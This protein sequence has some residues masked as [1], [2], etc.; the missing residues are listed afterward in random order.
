M[1]P[2]KFESAGGDMVNSHDEWDELAVGY[3]LTA[4]EPNELER[5]VGHLVSFCPDC[6]VSVH[7]TETVGAALGA[8]LPVP[9]PS[10][11]LRSQVLAAAL[12]A[13]PALPQ[14]SADL[15]LFERTTSTAPSI[16]EVPRPVGGAHRVAPVI[17]L[18]QRRKR[19]PSGERLGWLMAAAAAVVAVALGI[20][21]WSATQSSDNQRNK[22]DAIAAQLR[23][24]GT[25][26]PLKANGGNGA[27]IVTVVAHAGSV[28]VVA[29]GMDKTPKN[30]TYVLW[31]LMTSTSR[32]VA[33]G[34]FSVSNSSV[35]TAQVAA[36]STETYQGFRVF[37]VSQEPGH[38]PPSAP[39]DVLASGTKA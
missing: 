8:A 23:A 24:P 27:N 9:A 33:L 30:S 31:G 34:V 32:P 15:N 39:T 10:E 4:L 11:G 13:R 18:S 25:V 20:T 29:S 1:S 37:A 12:A 3:A 2:D 35:H 36:D 5:F 14:T 26:I 7:D 6:D 38:T 22:V 16:S 17:D 21:T 28:A 19:R